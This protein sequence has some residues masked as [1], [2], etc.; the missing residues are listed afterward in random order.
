MG[1][2]GCTP[3]CPGCDGTGI[4]PYSVPPQQKEPA[5]RAEIERLQALVNFAD[6][7]RAAQRAYMADRG[8]HEKGQAVAMAAR[9]YDE[10]RAAL[11]SKP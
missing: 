10:A 6:N 8:N 9:H 7:L 1:C 4:G 11:E 2:F 5:L 3:V